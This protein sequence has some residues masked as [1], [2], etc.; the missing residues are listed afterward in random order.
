MPTLGL[1]NSKR[2]VK[3]DGD[4]KNLRRYS[5]ELHS[6]GYVVCRETMHVGAVSVRRSLY[7][8]RKIMAPGLSQRVRFKN[9]NPLDCRKENLYVVG[10]PDEGPETPE[11]SAWS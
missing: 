3:I 4:N 5:W 2:R 11:L 9:K 1:K 10:P 8:H 6:N 7:L